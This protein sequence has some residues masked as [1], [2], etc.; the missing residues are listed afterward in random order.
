[1]VFLFTFAFMTDTVATLTEKV[2][3]YTQRDSQQKPCVGLS[4]DTFN[5]TQALDCVLTHC[6]PNN[7]TVLQEEILTWTFTTYQ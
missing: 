5:L 3:V 4:K 7:D 1:M 6:I 2:R